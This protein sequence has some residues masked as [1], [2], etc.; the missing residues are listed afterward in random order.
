[1]EERN[2]SDHLV[3][4][5]SLPSLDDDVSN[6]FVISFECSSI[7]FC[8]TQ[9]FVMDFLSASERLGHPW[10]SEVTWSLI[11]DA[12]VSSELVPLFQRMFS[13]ANLEL[14]MVS[15]M[16]R[17]RLC[18]IS[19]I[20]MIGEKLS[21]SSTVMKDTRSRYFR[22]GHQL[23]RKVIVMTS[24]LFDIHPH[25]LHGWNICQLELFL[26]EFMSSCHHYF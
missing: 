8:D 11:H 22:P 13:S 18:N 25:W 20:Q 1:M 26:C 14:W 15:S 9:V 23:K 24:S 12:F 17:E 7:R 16:I 2:H 5:S 21:S 3:C 4:V 6:V 10:T 19:A